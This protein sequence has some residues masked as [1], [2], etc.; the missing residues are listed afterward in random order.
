MDKIA[1][2]VAIVAG[3]SVTVRNVV[4]VV[5]ILRERGRDE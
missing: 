4:E 1:V 3:L 5:K 2:A